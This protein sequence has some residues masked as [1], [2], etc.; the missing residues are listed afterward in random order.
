MREG[1][2]TRHI[3]VD[4]LRPGRRT[5]GVPSRAPSKRYARTDPKDVGTSTVSLVGRSAIAA[6][7]AAT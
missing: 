5:T 4:A 1:M 2:L 7:Y 6:S 3:G